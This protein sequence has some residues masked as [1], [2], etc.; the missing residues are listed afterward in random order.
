MNEL[1][2]PNEMPVILCVNSVTGVARVAN[3]EEIAEYK[4]EQ[5]KRQ[6]WYNT[7][8]LPAP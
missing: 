1:R 4:A 2:D 8:E 7:A 6:V 5:E 3:Q